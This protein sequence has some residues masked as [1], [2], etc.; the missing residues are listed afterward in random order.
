[1]FTE[2]FSQKYKV[3]WIKSSNQWKYETN[4]NCFKSWQ[5]V[6]IHFKCILKNPKYMCL[7]YKNINMHFCSSDSIRAWCQ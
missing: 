3:H 2:F 7:Y 4:E 6:P 5:D 1:M